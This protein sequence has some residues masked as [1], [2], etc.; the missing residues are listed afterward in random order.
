MLSGK[1]L[2]DICTI[3]EIMRKQ[4]HKIELLGWGWENNKEKT[5]T[6]VTFPMGQTYTQNYTHM[7]NAFTD[8]LL[9]NKGSRIARAHL[10]WKSSQ[11][12]KQSQL[13]ILQKRHRHTTIYS[14][15]GERPVSRSIWNSIHIA[16]IQTKPTSRRIYRTKLN[17]SC[18]SACSRRRW[19]YHKWVGWEWDLSL[20]LQKM[21]ART[22]N[23]FLP[24]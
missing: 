3:K 6:F 24:D 13:N 12:A 20:L 15:S 16:K 11:N 14:D 22:G 5:G 9:R 8:E 4:L 19:L 21:N 23:S 7:V 1:L 2:S 18:P 17:Y 10:A